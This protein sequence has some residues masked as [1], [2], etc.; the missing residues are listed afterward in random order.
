M[1]ATPGREPAFTLTEGAPMRTASTGPATIVHLHL[2][3][4]GPDRG[5]G[6]L[7]D[8]GD[9]AGQLARTPGYGRFD[10]AGVAADYLV[11]INAKLDCLPPAGTDP[12]TVNPDGT[13]TG[14]AD[15]PRDPEADV[16]TAIS[17]VDGPDGRGF[18]RLAG[19]HVVADADFSAAVAG[20]AHTLATL[21][22]EV[23]RAGR[24]TGAGFAAAADSIRV[25]CAARQGA[26]DVGR[27]DDIARQADARRVQRKMP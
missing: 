25:L 6:F 27:L 22:E 11:A 5:F 19:A 16:A 9:V 4:L 13:I 18:W 1:T 14:R 21:A 12:L 10:A 8:R 26:L 7:E 23:E 17:Q 20:M 15:Y 2:A 24:H 3:D